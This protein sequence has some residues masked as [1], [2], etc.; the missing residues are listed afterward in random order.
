MRHQPSRPLKKNRF[1]TLREV[2][3]ELGISERSAWR[4]VEQDKLPAHEF[5]AST[6]V[7]REDLDGYIENSRRQRDAIPPDDTSDDGEPPAD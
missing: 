4:L 1:L 5:G 2:A 7:S 6:R 3:E